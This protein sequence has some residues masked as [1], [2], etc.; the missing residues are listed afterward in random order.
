MER[1]YAYWRMPD[2]KPCKGDDNKHAPRALLTAIGKSARINQEGKITWDWSHLR[3]EHPLL[4]TIVLLDE[5]GDE[6]NQDDAECITRRALQSVIKSRGAGSLIDPPAL[7]QEAN[8]LLAAFLREESK[9]YMLV[10]SLSVGSFPARCIKVEGCRVMPLRTRDHYPYPE[11]LQDERRGTPNWSPSGPNHYK[12]IR[13]ETSGRSV[14]EAAARAL[15]A[16]AVLCGLWSLFATYGSWSMRFGR[17][18]R[19]PIGVIALGPFHTLHKPDGA[20]ASPGYWYEPDFVEQH[21]TFS[22]T[23]GWAKIEKQRRWAMRK[24]SHLPFG[25]RL[26]RLIIRYAVA[27][28]KADLDVAFLHMW[29]ILEALTDTVGTRYEETVNRATWIFPDRTLAK[30]VLSYLRCYRNQY[31][32]AARS[33]ENSDQVAYLVKSFIDPHLAGLL[34]NDFGVRNLEEYASCLSLPTCINELR[35]RRQRLGRALRIRE[36][37]KNT[38]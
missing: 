25:D 4:G 27:L 37:W 30:E 6:L 35:T 26:R 22:P 38:E 21:K 33:R 3:I 7:L 2:G 11:P 28:G 5:N 19:K 31:V 9:E 29:S 17:Q 1:R 12:L 16:L 14:N 15:D 23:K 10:T 8:S 18:E 13:V 24:L 20:L 34:R 32:H 36:S